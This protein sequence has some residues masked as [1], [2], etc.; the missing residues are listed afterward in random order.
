MPDGIDLAV[1]VVPAREVI[2]SIEALGRRGIRA[3]VIFSSGFGEMGADG[4]AREVELITAASKAGVLICGPNCLGFVNAFDAV[5][6]TFSQYADGDTGAGPIAFVTQSGAFG[7]AIA[8]L[9]RQRGL[10]LGYFINTGN[11]ADLKFTDVMLRVV[12]DPRIKVAAGYLEG[13]EDGA[14]L[15]RLAE[16]CHELG[17]PLVIT[18]VGRKAAGQR[19]AASHTGALAVEDDVLDSVLRQYGILRA[20]NEEQMLDMLEALSQ[21]RNAA[22]NGLG[23]ATMSGGAGVMM[24]DRAEEVGL[25]VPELEAKTRARIASVMPAFGASANPVDVTGQFVA[26]P[27]LLREAVIALMDDPSIHVGIVWLQLMTAHVDKL[28]P[29][30]TEIRDRTTK[31]IF[32]CWTA[33]PQRAIELLRKEGIVVFGAGERAVEAAAALVRASASRHRI[34]A[35]EPLKRLSS[36]LVPQIK[37]HG[38]H[39]S[40][41]ATGWLQA[42]GIPMAAVTL[43]KTADQ[44]VVAWRSFARPVA[45]KI[46][47]PDITHKT[48]VGGVLLGLDGEATIRSGFDNLLTRARSARP[49]A[50]LDGVIVQP[51]TSGDVELV[52]GVQRSPVFGMIVMVGLGGILVEVLKDV[53]FRR[54]PFGF[55]EAESMLAELRASRILDGVR[56]KPAVDRK[57]VARMLSSLSEWAAAMAPVL[58]ELDS[59][60]GHGEPIRPDRRRLRDGDRT[61]VISRV[62]FTSGRVP[63]SNKLLNCC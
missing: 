46:E 22:G 45:L 10:G 33:A 44:A 49:T 40:V 42:A 15:I 55:D 28:V 62:W 56:G 18:K 39:P 61:R 53:A 34:A 30:F 37:T 26:D 8:A 54:A 31:P 3:A 35:Q 48:E 5:Y 27:G 47:S 38:V 14:A 25:I 4:K 58:Q 6:A 23:I 59:E 41:E 51:M 57:S 19:A 1:V 36:N 52:V 24:A 9:I 2:A 21:P 13:L 60:P 17:K 32:V 63:R 43:A 11:E 29:I 50:R 16:R 12:E 20:R 7:T